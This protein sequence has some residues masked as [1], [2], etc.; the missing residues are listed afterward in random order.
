MAKK[1]KCPKCG[2][3]FRM[4]YDGTVDGCDKCTGVER[5]KDGYVWG[6]D[7]Q[8]Q[9]RVPIAT[10]NKMSTWFK[11]TRAEAFKGKKSDG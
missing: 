9:T 10:A 4:G 2:Q 7:E 3:N 8:V 6:K 1:S 5:D 11:V